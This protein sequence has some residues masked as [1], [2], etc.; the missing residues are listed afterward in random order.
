MIRTIC[1]TTPICRLLLVLALAV[2]ALPAPAAPEASSEEVARMQDLYRAITSYH[3]LLD[4]EDVS[5]ARVTSVLYDVERYVEELESR[6]ATN[7]LF[8]EDPAKVEAMTEWVAKAHLQAALMHAK[9]VD[10]ER[11]ITQ[12][13][14]TIEL[15][16]HHPASWD[17][18]VERSA[19]PGLLP[20]VAEVVFAMASPADVVQDLERF[21]SAGVPTRFRIEELAP[22]DRAALRIEPATALG[23]AFADAAF[24]LA[25]ERFAARAAKGLEVFRVVLPPGRYRIVSETGAMHDLE[26]DLAPAGAPDPVVVNPN[27]FSFRYASSNEEC[28]P[29]LT[30]NGVVVKDLEGLPYGTYLVEAPESCP[31]RLPDK[32]T[33]SQHSE[34]TLR[35]EPEKLDYVREGE[36]ILV[37]ITTPPGST[38]TL[39]M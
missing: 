28:R 7:K 12:F 37:F 26:I 31:R 25:Q 27:T 34:V 20:D 35:T 3:V 39:R 1:Q 36:P 13:E 6:L 32:V 10:L 15:L 17:V 2:T 33:V 22:D 8:V 29:T 4:S 14:K 5:E 38:Y 19:S 11:S 30:I 21:W 9:G 18:E 16:G 23:S 24:A